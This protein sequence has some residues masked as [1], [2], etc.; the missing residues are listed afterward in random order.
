LQ[1]AY[2]EEN[3]VWTSYEGGYDTQYSS[4]WVQFN[5]DGALRHWD[6]GRWWRHNDDFVRLSLASYEKFVSS[7]SVEKDCI[8]LE[9]VK[10]SHYEKELFLKASKS[11]DDA[12]YY[13]LIWSLRHTKISRGWRRQSLI[14]KI[15]EN[16]ANN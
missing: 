14:L 10:Y 4:W 2:I 8:I 13:G 6:Q 7:L 1:Q 12:W 15:F 9:D 16:I 3:V 5:L 11:V